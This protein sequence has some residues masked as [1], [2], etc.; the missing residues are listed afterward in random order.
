M[1]DRII[2]ER[3]E[4]LL[5]QDIE[6]TKQVER[7][8]LP[9]R[10]PADWQE[11]TVLFGA[12]RLGLRVLAG[13]RR[14]GIQPIAFV[15]NN[16]AK[17]EGSLG[18]LPVLSPAESLDRFGARISF[19]VCVWHSCPIMRQ[20]ASMGCSSTV[21]FKAL[22]WHFFEEF[23]PNMRV[24]RP[25]L[26]LQDATAV[27][28]AYRSLADDA[29]RAEFVTQ[30]EWLLKYD[31]AQLE[32]NSYARQYFEGDIFAPHPNEIFVD[33]GAYDGDTIREYLS[34]YGVPNEIHAFEPDP[35]NR[36]ILTRWR[37]EQDA[38]LQ[39]RIAIHPYA[40]SSAH[41][42]LRFS[43][44]GVGSAVDKCGTIEV[45]ARPLDEVLDDK[46]VTFVKM[47]IEGGEPDAI[48]GAARLISSARPVLAVCVYHRQEH[49]YS[50]PNQLRSI[51]DGYKFFIRRYGDEFGDVVCYA[52]PEERTAAAAALS[53][54]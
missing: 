36:S 21:E 3:L 42:F 32:A 27:I 13:L 6:T 43:V 14:L 17:R 29:S 12:G 46:R 51:T 50:I 52:V 31:F 41:A 24:N 30:I 19:I 44:D 23:L 9:S 16:A 39:S 53:H 2:A 11:S 20:L 10:L 34:R 5:A 48:Q 1:G 37:C 40:V 26:I 54:V 18:G 15:D 22:F 28:A 8:C 45:E 47:D 33:C 4:E 35:D 25:N 49:I 7:N 38:T